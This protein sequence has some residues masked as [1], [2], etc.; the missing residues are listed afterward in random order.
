MFTNA[1]T[2]ELPRAMRPASLVA[3]VCPRYAVAT[4]RHAGTQGNLDTIQKPEFLW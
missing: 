4:E 2:I 3:S 1:T